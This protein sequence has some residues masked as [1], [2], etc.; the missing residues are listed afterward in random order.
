MPSQTLA[1]A[2]L[3]ISACPDDFDDPD[4]CISVD[5]DDGEPPSN[6]YPPW[7]WSAWQDR[8][9]RSIAP[10]SKEPIDDSPWSP[11]ASQTVWTFA[12]NFWALSETDQLGYMIK[13]RKDNDTVGRGHWID[14]V[15]FSWRDWKINETVDATLAEHGFDPYSIMKRMKVAK[16]IPFFFFSERRA[17]D[18]AFSCPSSPW[19]RCQCAT[20]TWR[21]DF[22]VSTP[23]PP[24]E[25]S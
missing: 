14:Y 8:T 24:I 23:S 17:A 22:L 15:T 12:S 2:L 5:D 16:V 20:L 21:K 25:R 10:F 6:L 11:S 19:P 9:G 4:D 13:N 1:G 18:L 7:C 3:A